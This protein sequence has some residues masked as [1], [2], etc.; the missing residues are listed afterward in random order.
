MAVGKVSQEFIDF[1]TDPMRISGEFRQNISKILDRA[2]R[3]CGTL[4]LRK[5][6]TAIAD[7]SANED[8]ILGKNLKNLDRRVE[9]LA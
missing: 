3:R 8:E 5:S 7:L 6:R 9:R 2:G 1:F 4:R